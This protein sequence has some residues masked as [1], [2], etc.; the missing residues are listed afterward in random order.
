MRKLSEIKNRTNTS[1]YFFFRIKIS[2]A[3]M[4]KANNFNLTKKTKRLGL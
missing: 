2:G 4:I 1:F 3:K